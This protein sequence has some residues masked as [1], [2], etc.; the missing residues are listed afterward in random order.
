MNLELRKGN[1]TIGNAVK[2]VKSKKP[3]QLTLN[4]KTWDKVIPGIYSLRLFMFEGPKNTWDKELGQTVIIE[5]IK[6]TRLY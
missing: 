1:K 3:E 5:D 6:V 2:T 4:I